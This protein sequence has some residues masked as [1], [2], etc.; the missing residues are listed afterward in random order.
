L[1]EF[2]GGGPYDIELEIEN[3][4]EPLSTNSVSEESTASQTIDE[5]P[6]ESISAPN[7]QIAPRDQQTLLDLILASSDEDIKKLLRLTNSNKVCYGLSISE[8]A[9]M[10][11][12]QT[13]FEKGIITQDELTEQQLEI[14]PALIESATKTDRVEIK[15]CGKDSELSK[16]WNLGKKFLVLRV[17][18]NFAA[19]PI[20]WEIQNDLTNI[21]LEDYGDK[22]QKTSG[23]TLH[24][25]EN[26]SILEKLSPQKSKSLINS[27]TDISEEIPSVLSEDLPAESQETINSNTIQVPTFT[28]EIFDEFLNQPDSKEKLYQAAKNATPD[29]KAFLAA[30]FYQLDP[31]SFSFVMLSQNDSKSNRNGGMDRG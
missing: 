27:T 17:Q 4:T 26:L 10:E 14:L 15:S 13:A 2:T 11:I 18:N 23:R 9:T 24:S 19:K 25:I 3:D 1:D 12:F 7:E 16:D 31:G 6:S 8:I 30:I 20:L 22:I 21:L 29:Q 5:T 28:G